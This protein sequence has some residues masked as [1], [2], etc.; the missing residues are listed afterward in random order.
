MRTLSIHLSLHPKALFLNQV[1]E[2]IFTNK[3]NRNHP[4][5]SDLL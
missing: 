5:T 1:A 2:T 3:V 4:I